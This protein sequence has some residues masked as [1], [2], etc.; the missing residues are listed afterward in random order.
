MS[1]FYKVLAFLIV[2]VASGIMGF[3]IAIATQG[4][5][6]LGL[7]TDSMIAYF[8]GASNFMQATNQLEKCDYSE[9]QQAI[10]NRDSYI[11]ELEQRLIEYKEVSDKWVE[12]EKQWIAER[13][14]LEQEITTWKKGSTNLLKIFQQ[15]TLD[16]IAETLVD[17]TYDGSAYN[18]L[19]HI[20][21]TPQEQDLLLKQLTANAHFVCQALKAYIDMGIITE[22]PEYGEQCQKI[23][24]LFNSL[25]E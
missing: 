25:K 13:E 15:N 10:E 20:A 18:V 24:E 2:A 22:V 14:I 16:M 19:L 23:E 8:S 4:D 3:F 11:K 21:Q 12:A 5:A 6:K 1:K 17:L 7:E 9:W